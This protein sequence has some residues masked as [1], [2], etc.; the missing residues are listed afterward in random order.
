MVRVFNS[1]SVCESLF[2][3][4]MIQELA[5]ALSSNTGRA[6]NTAGLM[7]GCGTSVIANAKKLCDVL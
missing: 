6:M 1:L 5:H 4:H 7:L 3:Q 2:D